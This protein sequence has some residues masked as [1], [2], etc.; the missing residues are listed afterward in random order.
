[1]E[2]R[3]ISAE[4][5]EAGFPFSVPHLSASRLGLRISSLVPWFMQRS[6]HASFLVLGLL[7]TV[8][9]VRGWDYEGHRIVNQLGLA[10]LP[11]DFP[12]FVREPANAERI[13]FLAGEPD[14]WR[15]VD[16][17]LQQ[18]GPS[19]TDHFL[20]VEELGEAGLAPRSVSSFR[21]EF[22]VAFAAG[23]AAHADKFPVIDPAR[24]P[25]RTREWPGFAPWA[26]AEWFQKLR[27]AFSYLKA[28][29]EVG[30]TSEEI[31]QAKA[32]AVY[33]MGVMGHYVGD[34]AQPLHTTKHYNGWTGPNPDG[35]TTAPGIHSWI[36]SGFIAKARITLAD[37]APRST[38]AEPFVF[39]PREDGRDPFFVV[40]LDYILAQH[41]LV[42]P[43][44]RLE[45]DGLL[46]RGEQPV[47]PEGQAFIEGQLLKGGQMLGRIWVTAWRSAPV[48]LY[49]RAQLVKRQDA[50]A[51]GK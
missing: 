46:G 11:A 28:F 2:D 49:L 7:A 14:R 9:T 34:C 48:D 51:A 26:I 45:K 30:G 29:E 23:R 44:Y 38:P 24:N 18:V 22:A 1:M 25:A 16:P 35:Y 20:D 8:A 10:A 27:S 3:K 21:L 42:E 39:A 37:L 33:L 15:N 31:A 4:L 19:W 32:N 43:L 41:E 12:A 50:A 6:P 5:R 47:T 17:W 13:A 36:D 40:A